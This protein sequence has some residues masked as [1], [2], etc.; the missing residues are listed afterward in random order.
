MRPIQIDK[1]ID[2]LQSDENIKNLVF[3]VASISI[4]ELDHV[5]K[6]VSSLDSI[7]SIYLLGKPPETKEQLN[8]FFT[9]FDKI[10][11]FCEDEDQLA[12]QLVLDMASNCR[13]S[14]NQCTAAGDRDTA[15]KH[16]QRGMDLY[17]GLK[18]FINTTPR[19]VS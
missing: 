17:D 5:L 18:K 9:D 2:K 19:K 4:Q 14:G 8:T 15:R 10:C 3:E 16:F 7:E 12:V 11:M 1:C 13:I 6:A